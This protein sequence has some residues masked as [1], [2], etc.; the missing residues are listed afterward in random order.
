MHSDII[1][2]ESLPEKTNENGS[3]FFDFAFNRGMIIRR[4][5]FHRRDLKKATW[6]ATDGK[7]YN[8]IDHYRID[9]RHQQYC[10]SK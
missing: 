1:G 9:T 10:R 2:N 4:A 5:L 8:Q 6:L 3:R 7:A